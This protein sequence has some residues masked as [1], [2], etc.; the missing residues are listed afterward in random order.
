MWLD[1]VRRSP[2]DLQSVYQSSFLD[3]SSNIE[4][5]NSPLVPCSHSAPVLPPPVPRAGA[6]QRARQSEPD[7][8]N[9]SRH[10]GAAVER[11]S[12]PRD[13]QSQR[14]VQPGRVP[15]KPGEDEDTRTSAFLLSNVLK[16][17]RRSECSVIVSVTWHWQ[18]TNGPNQKCKSEHTFHV[19][20]FIVYFYLMYHIFFTYSYCIDLFF[21]VKRYFLSFVQIL[22]VH[23]SASTSCCIHCLISARLFFFFN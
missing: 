19:I 15:R 20:Y 10:A 3:V 4:Q 1:V 5:C 18:L 21:T 2:S 8:P 16:E 23:S 11:I 12:G 7:H 17:Q 9:Q 14:A 13:H 6:E 22:K